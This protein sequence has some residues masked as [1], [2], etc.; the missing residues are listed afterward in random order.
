MNPLMEQLE[1]LKNQLT[2]KKEARKRLSPNDFK[3]IEEN[4]DFRKF[5][6]LKYGVPS[7]NTVELLY[8][9]LT[10]GKDSLCRCGD[11]KKFYRYSDG[12][13]STCGKKECIDLNRRDNYAKT[14]KDRYGVNHAS[15]LKTT[16]RAREE[17]M[18]KKY[19]VK[20]NWSGDLRKTSEDSM[21]SKYGVKHALQNESLKKKRNETTI[22]NHGTLNMLGLSKTI[23]TNMKLY[24]FDN[25]SK[26]SEIIDKIK[27]S[28]LKKST[29]IASNKLSKF[30]I[31][32]S[33]YNSKQ[34][35]Y[36]LVC[37]TCGKEFESPGCSVNVKLRRNLNPCI[38]CNPTIKQDGTSNLEK[39]IFDFI[40]D[41]IDVANV[42]F[43]DRVEV[44]TFELDVY[45]PEKKKAIE[46][47]GVYWHSEMEK[48]PNYHVLKNKA[49]TAKGINVKH[50]W[51][52]SWNLKK[53]IVKSMITNW[54][55]LNNTIYARKCECKKI[56]NSDAFV[57]CE[58]NHLKGGKNSSVA[59]GLFNGDEIVSVM[60]FIKIKNNWV[61]D[62]LCFKL[63]LNVVGG[64]SKMFSRFVRDES[65]N[66]ISTWA[67][68]DLTPDPNKSIYA[69]LGFQV[70]QWTPSYSWV[71]SGVRTNRQKFTKDKLVKIGNPPEKSEVEIMHDLGFYRT[72]ETGNWKFEWQANQ[73]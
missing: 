47:N 25:A 1:D 55:N 60:T 30:N 64:A 8:Y 27:T 22:K 53:P 52:D 61:L 66:K 4:E 72:F 24:G 41:T 15:Q 14:V 18:I 5:V 36:S 42:K 6:S 9:V 71:V 20:H 17:T 37:N 31:V 35:K 62:R 67:D 38:F 51:E 73:K 16:I 29:E 45:F 56:N 7:E 3:T 65:P 28:N 21:L 33:S 39:E 13:H 63:G 48:S 49:I 34:Q 59:Y 69:K 19:G 54:L 58:Q 2:L 23:S 26:N 50:I 43:N 70:V 68:C 10:D 57:F 46:I 44:P 11:K 40:K 32:I 12:H